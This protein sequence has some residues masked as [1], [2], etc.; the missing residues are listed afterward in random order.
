MR[1]NRSLVSSRIYGEGLRLEATLA[2]REISVIV[3]KSPIF[4]PN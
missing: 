1:D 3:K 2:Y 4:T